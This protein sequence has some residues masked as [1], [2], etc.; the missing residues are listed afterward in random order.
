MQKKTLRGFVFA[1]SAGISWGFSGSCG[2][3]IFTNYEVDAAWLAACRMMV[4]GLLM[5][6]FLLLK[7][8][9]KA[10]RLFKNR[11][12]TVHLLFFAV[13]GFMFCQY[14]YLAAIQYSNA[15][16]ATVLQYLSPVLVLIYACFVHRKPP[17]LPEIVAILL[18]VFG[19]FMVAT[20]GHISSMKL[21]GK[22]LSWGLLSA[23]AYCLYTIL[24]G[25]LVGKYG[26]LKVTGLA[27]LIGGIV[28]CLLTRVWTIGVSLDRNG[29]AAFAAIVILGTVIP[30]TMFLQA[31]KDIGTVKTSLIT[32]IEP[33]AATVISAIWLKSTFTVADIAGMFCILSTVVLATLQSRQTAVVKTTG[34]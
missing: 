9:F 18:A 27:M 13:F 10:F 31:T 34:T 2:Q 5:V 1:V 26:S 33:V 28:L 6:I 7:F 8:R 12:D 32:C 16:T 22:G 23:L 29:L 19:T 24:P 3:Y 25:R 21:T 14:A 11:R 4:S 20:H 15:G 30:F 17:R